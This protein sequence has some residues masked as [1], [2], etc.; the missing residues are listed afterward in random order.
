MCSWHEREIIKW[1][2]QH[3]RAECRNSVV[4]VFFHSNPNGTFT[5]T[6][7]IKYIC[8]RHGLLQFWLGLVLARAF[9]IVWPRQK[10]DLN[11]RDMRLTFALGARR[12]NKIESNHTHQLHTHT[13][14]THTKHTHSRG[15][16]HQSLVRPLLALAWV[17]GLFFV[18]HTHSRER[19][20]IVWLFCFY[21]SHFS[22]FS[23]FILFYIFP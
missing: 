23:H 17:F 2:E 14:S 4:L 10:I 18:V 9:G 15:V 6:C 22:Y 7:I 12:Q 5:R 20:S 3:S 19:A 1:I 13:H 8:M 16:S 11:T 21:F